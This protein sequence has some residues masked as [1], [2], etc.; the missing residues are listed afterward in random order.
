MPILLLLLLAGPLA[1]QG[2]HVLAVRGESLQ[3]DGRDFL[4]TGLRTSNA[5]ISDAAADELIAHMDTFAAYGVNTFGVYFM[6]SR[7]GD[8][9]GYRADGTIDPVYG[10][11]ME[12]IV[13]AAD[14][15]GLVVLVGALYWGTSAATHHHWTQADAERAI[16]NTVAWLRERELRNVFID[17]DNEGMAE[18]AMG[19]DPEGLVRAGKAVDPRYL[20]ALNSR[21][22]PAPS[23]DLHIHFAPPVPGK[24]YVESEGTTDEGAP[25]R[26]WGSYSK[27]PDLYNYVRVGVHGAE[28]RRALK[29]MTAEHLR[30]GHGY[31]LASTWLQAVPPRGPNHRP[32]GTGTEEDPGIRWWLEF[33]GALRRE[34]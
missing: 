6:G 15:R 8:V 26:Y 4:V 7:F 30:R 31:M 24:P 1:A 32:G 16:A 33:V 13:R 17:V 11:R 34:P 28:N 2:G 20:V 5:L 19:F 14:A 29:R 10:A 27:R 12:R 9:K 3:L 22:K 25:G 23:A 21:W 18:R